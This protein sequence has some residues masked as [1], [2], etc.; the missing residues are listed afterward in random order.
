M[1][2][3]ELRELLGSDVLLLRWPRGSKGTNKQWGHL[4]VANMTPAYL[5]KLEDG[6]IGVALGRKSGNLVALDIDHDKMVQPFLTASP[7][8]SN[9][10][11]TRGARGRVFWIRMAGNYPAVTRKLRHNSGTECGEWRAGT[12]S[13]SI[14]SGIHPSGSPYKIICRAKPVSLE[15]SN[16]IW[17]VEISNPPRIEPELAVSKWTEGTEVTEA[18]KVADVTEEADVI[19]PAGS[20][21]SLI[22]SVDGAVKK[23]LPEKIHTNN[24][25]LFDLAR[26]LLTL[27][28]KGIKHDPDEVFEL[29]YG[30]AKPLLRPELTKEDYYIEFMNAC[31][32][33]KI[34]FGSQM[35][36]TA[37]E[38]AKQNLLPLPT[39]AAAWDNPERK[40]LL[41][42]FREMQAAAGDKPFFVAGGLRTCAKLLGHDSHSTVEKW[43]G[44]FCQLKF[45]KVAEKGDS[46]RATRFHYSRSA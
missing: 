44:A 28:A 2:V 14:I 7:V 29:W 17:P 22:E 21:F 1:S 40:L 16:I 35:V 43:I 13:Q 12:N 6:N 31:H 42:F 37:W 46:H 23:C 45:L 39:K 27:T 34:P 18:T 4:T 8:L 3:T 11:Q 32:R 41:A 15:F 38:R 24:D 10:L 19:V 5:Q 20:V 9:T 25:R 30:R 26:A 33:A 36:A